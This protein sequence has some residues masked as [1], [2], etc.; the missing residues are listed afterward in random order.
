MKFKRALLLISI[1]SFSLFS[2]GCGEA[3]YTMTDE[4]E[5]IITLY[6]AK[7]VNKFNKNQTIGIANARIRPGELDE[8]YAARGIDNPYTA[9][10][11]ALNYNQ[12]ATSSEEPTDTQN[13]DLENPELANGDTNPSQQAESGPSI[14]YSYSLT[15]AIGIGDLDFEYTGMDIDPSPDISKFYAIYAESGK[16]FVV[17][18]LDATNNTNSSVNFGDFDGNKYGLSVNN[19]S[20]YECYKTVVSNDL[21]IYNGSIEPGETKSFLLVFQLSSS[22]VSDTSSLGLSVDNNGNIRGTIINQQ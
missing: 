22:S 12:D 6:S 15:D 1:M 17:L 7:I 21:S 2:T 16:T 4:E 3:L 5:T 9:E 20:L 18:H 10:N 13:P 19:S 8:A 11:E 14:D